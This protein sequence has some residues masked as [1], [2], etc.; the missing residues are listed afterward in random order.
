MPQ[1]IWTHPAIVS[2]PAAFAVILS[3]YMFLRHLEKLGKSRD[4]ER[5]TAMETMSKIGTDFA[6]EIHVINENR[7]AEQKQQFEFYREQSLCM[8]QIVEK[9]GGMPKEKTK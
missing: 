5:K 4:E 6:A 7:V 8:Q 1:S 3:T 9:C 2:I